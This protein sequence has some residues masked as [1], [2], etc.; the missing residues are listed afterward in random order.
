M[1][2]S[3]AGAEMKINLSK[4]RPF[5]GS[6]EGWKRQYGKDW[7][8]ARKAYVAESLDRINKLKDRAK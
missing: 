7:K 8:K 3:M 5:I 6:D 1:V 2:K 4:I